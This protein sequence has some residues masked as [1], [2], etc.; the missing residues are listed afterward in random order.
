MTKREYQ[1]F[2]SIYYK[3]NVLSFNMRNLTYY[4]SD[5]YNM[6]I[7]IKRRRAYNLTVYFLNVCKIFYDDDD[8]GWVR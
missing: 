1:H 2:K 7:I 6:I 4:R 3:I 8:Y 5:V